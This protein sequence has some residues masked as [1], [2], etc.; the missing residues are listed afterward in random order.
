MRAKAGVTVHTHA[1]AGGWHGWQRQ[2]GIVPRRLGVAILSEGSALAD[3]YALG[4]LAHRE[5]G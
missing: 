5:L 1:L 3:G 2:K 4:D